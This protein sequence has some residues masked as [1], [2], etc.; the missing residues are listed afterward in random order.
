MVR[1]SLPEFRRVNLRWPNP[2]P[3]GENPARAALAELLLSLRCQKRRTVPF[4][5]P[6]R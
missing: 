5:Q 6:S 3:S 1:Q 4:I 2:Q